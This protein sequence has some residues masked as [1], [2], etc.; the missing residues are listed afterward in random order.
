MKIFNT[1]DMH[2]RGTTKLIILDFTPYK[3]TVVQKLQK[4]DCAVKLWFCNWSCDAVCSSEVNHF[5][6]YFTDKAWFY[7]NSNVNNQN[8]RHWSANNAQIIHQMSSSYIVKVGPW[9][10]ISAIRITLTHKILFFFCIIR[11]D[12]WLNVI[13]AYQIQIY[14]PFHHIT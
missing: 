12:G 3:L 2:R 13:F 10:A 1:G 5:L 8:T 9:C 14:F 7:W 11:L 4:A 6:T